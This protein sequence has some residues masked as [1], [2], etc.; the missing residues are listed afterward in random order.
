MRK[1]IPPR[2]VLL[3][4]AVMVILAW[5]LPARSLF[6]SWAR[7]LGVAVALGGLALT[8]AGSR[9]F[10]QRGTNIKTFDGPNILVIDGPFRFSRNPMYLGFTLFLV[11]VALATGVVTPWI[12][13]LCFAILAD[14]WYIPFEET[15]MSATFGDAYVAYRG[16]VNRWIGVS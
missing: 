3:L 2:L 1:L 10:H 13:P 15:Q 9:L 12:G 5:L 7:V 6:G 4:T 8:L 16:T 11:G 14:R